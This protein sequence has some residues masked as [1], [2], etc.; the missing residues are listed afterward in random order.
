[1]AITGGFELRVEP[2]VLKNK[3][4]EVDRLADEMDRRFRQMESYIN[5]TRN[6]WIG[7][8]GDLHRK[9]YEQKKDKINEMLRRLKEHPK[10]LMI[11]A[12]VYDDAEKG[13]TE[14]ASLLRGDVI[15]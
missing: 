10:D 5:S 14:D 13:N 11:M 4:L 3:A 9:L 2:I 7:E 6:M 15:V 1:M 8:A 12:G